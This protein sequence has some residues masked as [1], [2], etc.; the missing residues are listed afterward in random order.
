MS[1]TSHYSVTGMTY[2]ETGAWCPQSV[3]I[4]RLTKEAASAG[5]RHEFVLAALLSRALAYYVFKRFA[6]VDPARA[7]AKLTHARLESLPIPRV[8]FDI[9]DQKK[10]HDEI[11][12]RV[13]LLLDQSAVIGGVE[14]REIE[15]MLRALWGLSAD[16]GAFI[17]GEF[18]PLPPGQAI[19]ELF[20][21]GVPGAAVYHDAA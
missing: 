10:L 14:D 6:E 20:P 9:P 1:T 17:N 19:A 7:H 2:D 11:V 16:D 13:R 12:A 15:L 4:Y 18:A 5:Y 8:S 21:E 3:Y